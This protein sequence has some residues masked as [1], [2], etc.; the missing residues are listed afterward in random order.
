MLAGE[1]RSGLVAAGPGAQSLRW[2]G[3]LAMD[4]RPER[5]RTDHARPG[6]GEGGSL[7]SDSRNQGNFLGHLLLLKFTGSDSRIHSA[8][9]SRRCAA[10]HSHVVQYRDNRRSALGAVVADRS[11]MP[12]RLHMA[13]AWRGA[14]LCPV[15]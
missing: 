15:R 3:A 11:S 13:R 1:R 7:P 2:R 10:G 14:L 12:H 8:G 9:P 4:S 6:L 5:V